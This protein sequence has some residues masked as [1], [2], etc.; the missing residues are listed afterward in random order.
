MVERAYNWHMGK[1]RRGAGQSI[2]SLLFLSEI[3]KA[4]RIPIM[5]VPSSHAKLEQLDTSIAAE[6]QH[7]TG[8]H[9]AT[10]ALCHAPGVQCR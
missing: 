8:K 5:L 9:D 4:L 10:D 1:R 7:P 2:G 6:G 3:Q